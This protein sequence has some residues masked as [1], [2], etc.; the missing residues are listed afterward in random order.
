MLAL[1]L[2]VAGVPPAV[3]L[4]RDD[5]SR[6]VADLY[7]AHF[8]ATTASGVAMNDRGEVAGTSRDDLGC[9]PFCLPPED[10]VVWRNGKRIV[11]PTLPGY[12]DI[13][14]RGMN[15]QGWVV[16]MAGFPYTQTR[17]V[18][19]KPTGPSSDPTYQIID[20]GLLP[21]TIRSE[22]LGIDNLGRVVGWSTTNNLPP[23]GS[24]F[25]WTEAEGMVDLSAQGF[26]DETPLAISPGGWVATAS[27][28]YRLDDPR[29]VS[30]LPPAPPGFGVGT[31]PTAINDAGDQ[32][33]FLVNTGPENLVYLFRFH[34]EGTWQMVSTAGTGH[35]TTYGIGSINAARDVTAT[36]QSTGVIAAGPDGLATDLKDLLSPAYAGADVTRGG[37]MNSKGQILAQVMIGRST[38]LM[39]LN[40]AT[41]CVSNCTIVSEVPMQG[42]FVEDPKDPDHC[43]PDLEAYNRVRARVVV[44]DEAGDPLEGVEVQ[45][46]F[47]DDYWMDKAVS[48]TT[49]SAGIATFDNKG[50][51]GVGAVAFLVD[52]ARVQ[53]R[54]FDRTRG[55]VT[56]FVIPQ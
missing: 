6:D 45:G 27:A 12:N 10:T 19:W 9:G 56:N 42:K 4:D 26:P 18:V 30:F 23:N 35:L 48:G 20:L 38:R 7:V 11:L 13:Y 36:I 29:S 52:R 31:Y 32:A 2:G 17:A 1:T 16:G 5:G 41:P 53:S 47:L 54:V 43:A 34:H 21:G 28:W 3:G 39:K 15:N 49:D 51:C 44:T 40:P 8:V 55:I 37:P 33:R 24:P 14:V 22:A 25:L 50:P 46:R